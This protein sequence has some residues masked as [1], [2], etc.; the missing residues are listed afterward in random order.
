MGG[1]PMH[2]QTSMGKPPMPLA[3]TS[4]VGMKYQSHGSPNRET[5]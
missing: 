2:F 5:L 1:S 3:P 4:I